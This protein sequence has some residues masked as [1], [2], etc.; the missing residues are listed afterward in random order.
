MY[1]KLAGAEPLTVTQKQLGRFGPKGGQEPKFPAWGMVA[2]R[3]G[4]SPGAGPGPWI[5]SWPNGRWEPLQNLSELTACILADRV[6]LGRGPQDA[7]SALSCFQVCVCVIRR[8]H[9]RSK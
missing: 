1:L 8:L 7:A 2:D 6:K 5:G 4:R 9:I 3:Q